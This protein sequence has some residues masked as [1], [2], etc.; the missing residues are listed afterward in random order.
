LALTAGA[1]TPP[2]ADQPKPEKPANLP[3]EALK[4]LAQELDKKMKQ[5][6]I[7][8]AN[9]L[10]QKSQVCAIPLKNVIGPETNPDPKI[11]LAPPPDKPESKFTMKE[12]IPPAPSCEDR[13]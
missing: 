11:V 13:K 2:A 8:A 3:D 5:G 6:Q 9:P 1:Q 7:Q 10:W 4:R 12:V